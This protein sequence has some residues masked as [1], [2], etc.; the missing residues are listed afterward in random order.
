MYLWAWIFPAVVYGILYYRSDLGLAIILVYGVLQPVWSFIRYRI[1][2]FRWKSY[3]SCLF[4]KQVHVKYIPTYYF[5]LKKIKQSWIKQ[6]SSFSKKYEQ[7]PPAAMTV[8]VSI[9]HHGTVTAN[10]CFSP[11]R[12]EV[13]IVFK[14]LLSAIQYYIIQSLVISYYNIYQNSNK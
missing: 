11:L 8:Y 7:K 12:S 13:L 14:N 6:I 10:L 9:R 3:M 1:L 2:A 4:I 5:E